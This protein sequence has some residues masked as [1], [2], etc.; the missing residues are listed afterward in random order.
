MELSHGLVKCIHVL[1]TTSILMLFMKHV[2]GFLCV[3][4]HVRDGIAPILASFVVGL[5]DSIHS[6]Y[7]R[8][9]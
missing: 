1:H 8:M 2:I 9:C 3:P 5:P 7:Y 4:V 6:D